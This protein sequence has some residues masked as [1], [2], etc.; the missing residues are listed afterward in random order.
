MKISV[1]SDHAGYELKEI[2]IKWL[3]EKG[4]EVIN[5][6][7]FSDQSVDYPDYAHITASKVNNGSCERGIVICG[8][9]NGVSMTANKYNNVRAALCWNEE[10]AKL[11]RQHNDANIL[12]LPAR[13]ISAEEAIKMTEIFFSVPFEGGRHQI[14]VD[15][16][17]K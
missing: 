16:I 8:S 2:I 4:F 11:A 6:G 14:R 13:F 10:I 15:K 9:G 1:A 12:G 17:R 7:P 3:N 5:E